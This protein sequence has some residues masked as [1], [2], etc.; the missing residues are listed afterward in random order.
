MKAGIHGLISEGD[1]GPRLHE[2]PIKKKNACR[3]RRTA[4]I[5]DR[6][7][8]I[9]QIKYFQFQFQLENEAQNEKLK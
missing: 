7:W 5:S 8:N 3:I 4:F 6:V 2:P 9:E 1:L